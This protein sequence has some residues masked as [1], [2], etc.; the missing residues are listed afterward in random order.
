MALGSQSPYGYLGKD[1][2][3]F[4]H[5]PRESESLQIL[6]EGTKIASVMALGSQSPYGYLGKNKD[7]FRPWRYLKSKNSFSAS[8][9]S[10]LF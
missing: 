1:K 6:R 4:R 10:S 3:S 2:N 7:S 5:G 9:K 8:V